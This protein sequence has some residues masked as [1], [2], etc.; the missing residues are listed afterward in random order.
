[1]NENIK[2]LCLLVTNGWYIL[3]LEEAHMWQSWIE[4][5]YYSVTFFERTTEFDAQ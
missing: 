2:R 1:M 3:A 4:L 5:E